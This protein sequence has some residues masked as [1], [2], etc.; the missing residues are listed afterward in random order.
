MSSATSMSRFER[1]R[2]NA[3][4][5]Y[6]EK[7]DGTAA[8]GFGVKNGIESFNN[9]YL[10][11]RRRMKYYNGRKVGLIYYSGKALSYVYY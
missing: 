1:A 3:F 2:M 9:I 6:L 5:G 7:I 4:T 11:G 8:L 10:R